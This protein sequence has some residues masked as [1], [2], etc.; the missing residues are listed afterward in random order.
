MAN[1]S[2]RFFWNDW[3]GDPCLRACGLAA[4]GLWMDMLCLAAEAD[5]IGYVIVGQRPATATDLAR[6]TGASESEV[7]SLLTELDR[8]GVFSRDRK[9]RIYCRR[10]VRDARVSADA[11]K[12]GL[13]GG[14]PNLRRGTVPKKDR[15]RPFKRTDAP[16]KTLRIFQKSGG[17]C[18]WCA[19]PLRWEGDIGPDTFHV[20]HVKAVCD[21]G[22]ND[23]ANLVAACAMCNHA[24]AR[25]DWVKPPDP[26]PDPK[27][28]TK[29]PIPIPSPVPEESKE[30][31]SGTAPSGAASDYGFAGKVI[32]LKWQAFARWVEAFRHLD[33]RAE[34]TGRDDWLA[35]LPVDDR[36]RKDWYIPTSNWLIRKNDEA[37]RS[38]SGADAVDLDVLH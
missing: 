36:R 10:M 11:R 3:R 8:N 4:R 18:H 24:R 1:A 17:K 6:L 31:G 29:P 35:T 25:K 26:N 33:L 2:S 13:E 22:T 5:P 38:R 37:M 16:A 21:G 14:N 12:A 20:D 7:E 32:R 27:A 19:R 23:E 28:D 9:A 15:S 30:E 34:L